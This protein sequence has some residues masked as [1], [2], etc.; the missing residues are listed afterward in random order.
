MEH[1]VYDSDGLFKY[2]IICS[3]QSLS[4]NMELIPEEC[5]VLEYVETPI[6]IEKKY[7]DGA[8]SVI[9]RPEMEMILS[10]TIEIVADG[11]QTAN[12]DGIPTP[13]KLLIDGYPQEDITEPSLSFT[14]DVAGVYIFEFIRAPYINKKILVTAI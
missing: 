7:F 4:K 13:C 1:Y 8:N 6:D 12:I 3:D 9:D 14:L 5:G 11:I 2:S 10:N